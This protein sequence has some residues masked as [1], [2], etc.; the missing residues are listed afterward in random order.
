MQLKELPLSNSDIRQL[1]EFLILHWTYN[2]I[3]IEENPITLSDTK[4]IL[5]PIILSE[6]D[7]ILGRLLSSERFLLEILQIPTRI[8]KND[9]LKVV[10]HAKAIDY[11]ENLVNEKL[12]LAKPNIKDSFLTESNIKDIDQIIFNDIDDIDARSERSDRLDR[13]IEE[14]KNTHPYP[15]H[16]PEHVASYFMPEHKS[17]KSYHFQS[18]PVKVAIDIHNNILSSSSSN[19][20]LARLILN[21]E[22]LISGFPAIIIK[23][24]DKSNYFNGISEIKKNN[25][26]IILTQLIFKRLK[27]AFNRHWNILGLEPPFKI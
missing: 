9:I 12:T 3:A 2:S 8:P 7:S 21:F 18:H 22:L 16:E 19:G 11:V 4:S 24:T 6:T 13:V 26:D 5:D 15:E 23:E 25:N 27:E 1:H 20:R 17:L 10:N 14:V